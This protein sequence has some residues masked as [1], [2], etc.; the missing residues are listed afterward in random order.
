MREVRLHS[1]T[2]THVCGYYQI[3]Q[4]SLLVIK[5]TR[6]PTNM[7]ERKIFCSLLLIEDIGPRAQ[8][9]LLLLILLTRVVR[10]YSAHVQCTL[11]GGSPEAGVQSVRLPSL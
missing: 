8:S 4:L 6:T 3:T 5:Y 9:S 7:Q 2:N 11:A 1:H 10:H